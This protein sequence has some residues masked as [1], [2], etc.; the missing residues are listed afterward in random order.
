MAHYSINYSYRKKGYKLSG[1]TSAH[2]NVEAESDASAMA[3][4][5]SKHPDC[6]VKFNQVKKMK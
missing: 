2:A 6:D 1:D 4:I 5:K 3:I